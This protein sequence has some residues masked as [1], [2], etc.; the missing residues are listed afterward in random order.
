VTVDESMLP[1]GP[2]DFPRGGLPVAGVLMEEMT[3]PPLGLRT[4]YLAGVVVVLPD[5]ELELRILADTDRIHC[6]RGGVPVSE[7]ARL[8]PYLQVDRRWLS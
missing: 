5:G 8:K 6:P 4:R 3:L 2:E 1:V 7:L